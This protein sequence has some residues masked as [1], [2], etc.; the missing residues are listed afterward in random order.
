MGET[1][2]MDWKV[3]YLKHTMGV[4]SEGFRSSFE[5]GADKGS[6]VDEVCYVLSEYQ[7]YAWQPSCTKWIFQ[8]LTYTAKV[9]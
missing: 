1:K 6:R 3:C 9:N 7:N 4:S 5:T 2:G 8:E